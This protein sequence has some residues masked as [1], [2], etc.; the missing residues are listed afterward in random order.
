MFVLRGVVFFLLFT[1]F[2]NPTFKT[3][4]YITNKPKLSIL[5][6]NSRSIKFLEQEQ[7][8][9]DLVANI[10]NSQLNDKYEISYY[11]FGKDL[12]LSDS[13]DLNSSQSDI[14]KSI[15]TVDNLSKGNHA[16]LLLSDGNQ[17][18]GKDYE[19]AK[20]KAYTYPVILGDTTKIEDLE[21]SLVNVNKY[22]YIKNK[23]PVEIQLNYTGNKTVKTKL[24]I[25]KNNQRV[26][27]QSVTFDKN[28]TS[29]TVTTT[30]ES[31]KEGVQLYKVNL[32]PL[33]EE[34]NLINNSA[35]FGIE[36]INEQSE[37]LILSSINHPDIGALRRS[38]EVNQQRKVNVENTLDDLG[39]LQKYQLVILYQPTQ[40]E[41]EIIQEILAKKLNFFLITGANTDWSFLNNINIGVNKNL[42]SQ[43]EE[44]H[45]EFNPDFYTFQQDDIGFEDFPPLL[46][47]YGEVNF[48]E[49]HQ[50]LL[51]QRINGFSSGVPLLA[52]VKIN[53][54]K[55]G[56]LLGEG[57][58]KWRSGSFLRTNSFNEFD[59][60]TNNIIQYLISTKKRERLEVSVNRIYKSNEPIV[61]S[62]FYVDENYVFDSRAQLILTIKDKTS[63]FTKSF[64]FSLKNNSFETIVEDLPFGSYT[65][66]VNVS[67][68]NIKKSG[69]F[70]VLEYQIEQQFSNANF[71]KLKSLADKNKGAVYFPNQI[72]NLEQ[73]LMQNNAL[74]SVQSAATI[75]T[76]LVDWKIILYIIILLL[77][78]EWFIRKYFGLI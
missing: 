34:K 9:K 21:I 17:T 70:D 7:V 19:Y 46:D 2:I 76:P 54:Q 25:T 37:I 55:K 12:V 44:Y 75:S 31:N 3:T 66:T 63:D 5:L 35:S 13:I 73:H 52:T 39:Q 59:E 71:N 16:I 20:L 62:A 51:Y 41:S 10:K 77:A 38:I 65:Y 64:P 40:K 67:N 48:T 33:N 50:G 57:L 78:L 15:K 1:L 36:V 29:K 24:Q 47:V 6:D 58:W 26:F 49:E 68:Q 30:L 4:S 60:F 61:F 8:I 74:Q 14:F 45:V 53:E 56:F 18:T 32:S 22:S 27:N 72:S 43:T 11:S 23:F 42:I 69:S 28:N